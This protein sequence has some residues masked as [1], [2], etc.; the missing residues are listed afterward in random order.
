MIMVF[1]IVLLVKLLALV[2]N[3]MRKLGTEETLREQEED[4]K[5]LFEDNQISCWLKDFSEVKD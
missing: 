5:S 3:I 4:L 1:I 2:V